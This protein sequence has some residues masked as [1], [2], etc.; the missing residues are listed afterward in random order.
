MMKFKKIFIMLSFFLLTLL[1]PSAIKADMM[2]EML[3]PELHPESPISQLEI[4]QRQELYNDDDE[5]DSDEQDNNDYNVKT[6]VYYE[7]S[8]G[9]KHSNKTNK[10]TKY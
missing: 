6:K 7:D 2:D 3:F 9:N 8:F 1:S 4:Q 10:K 5:N